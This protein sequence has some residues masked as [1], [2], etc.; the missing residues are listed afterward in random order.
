MNVEILLKYECI[1]KY[2][3]KSIEIKR[4]LNLV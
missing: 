3:E 1:F 4:E 2:I